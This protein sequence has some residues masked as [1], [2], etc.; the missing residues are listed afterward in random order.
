MNDQ[1]NSIEGF[2]FCHLAMIPVRR[3]PSHRSEMTSQLLFG[4][5][6]TIVEYKEEWARIINACDGYDGWIDSLQVQ[7]VTGEAFL[8]CRDEMSCAHEVFFPLQQKGL[9]RSFFIPMGSSLPGIIDGKFSIAGFQYSYSGSY[10]PPGT[11]LD[12]RHLIDLAY[13]YLDTPYLWGGR[14]HGGI[15]C[16]GYVQVIY[17]LAGYLLP[18]DSS[19]QSGTGTPVNLIS[20]AQPG[21]LLFFDNDEGQIVHVGLLL[22]DNQIIHASG[23]VRIDRVDH[24][25]IFNEESQRYTHKLR[26]IKRIVDS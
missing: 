3:E 11:K 17:K 9:Q 24:Q 13:Q 20:E 7:A 14:T 16:S 26:L 12:R 19:E 2:G 25:G 15:D 5:V 21:D 6:Y 4:E 22:P 10:L 8:S 1:K 18:R 23:K